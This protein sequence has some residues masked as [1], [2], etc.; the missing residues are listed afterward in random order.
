MHQGSSQVFLKCTMLPTAQ[1]YWSPG[2]LF[3]FFFSYLCQRA[4][5]QSSNFPNTFFLQLSKF[6][7]IQV[8]CQK[9][10]TFQCTH[11][12]TPNILAGIS[13]VKTPSVKLEIC[14]QRSSEV[15]HNDTSLDIFL[16]PVIPFTQTKNCSRV[17]GT[18][19]LHA[20]RP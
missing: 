18:L 11:E 7:T 15:N 16:L 17:K 8:Q 14:G 2:L 3:V 19:V 5:E 12:K 13:Q 10:R 4:R 9:I 20:A 6:T 1:A